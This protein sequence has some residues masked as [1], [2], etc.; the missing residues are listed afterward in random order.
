MAG[1]ETCQVVVKWIAATG[2]TT[3]SNTRR[4]WQCQPTLVDL[5]LVR[6][7]DAQQSCMCA[8]STQALNYPTCTTPLVPILHLA[9]GQRHERNGWSCAS[10]GVLAAQQ[11]HARGLHWLC[12]RAPVPL[13]KPAP[14]LPSLAHAQHVLSPSEIGPFRPEGPVIGSVLRMQSPLVSRTEKMQ[15]RTFIAGG[16][17]S[18]TR[19][20]LQLKA[21]SAQ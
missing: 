17:Q 18:S 12:A 7:A 4:Q 15:L 10:V 16:S 13:H 9:S 20:G 21:E 19:P 1:P 8:P 3:Y 11:G 6:Q 14:H 5:G 2:K